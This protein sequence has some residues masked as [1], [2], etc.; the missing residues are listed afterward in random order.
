MPEGVSFSRLLEGFNSLD[1]CSLYLRMLG[2]ALQLK[3]TAVLVLFLWL[4]NSEK[5]VNNRIVD[6]LEKRGLYSDFQYDFRSSCST[7]NLLKVV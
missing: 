2:E 7:A 3:T 5:L 4:I 6:H 1:R